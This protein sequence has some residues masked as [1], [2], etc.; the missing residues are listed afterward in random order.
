MMILSLH[1]LSK[2]YH[3][4]PSDALERSTTFDFQVLNIATQWTNKQNNKDKQVPETKE[5]SQEELLA[6]LNRSKKK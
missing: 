1:N 6:L 4:L 2:E 5:H 3:L